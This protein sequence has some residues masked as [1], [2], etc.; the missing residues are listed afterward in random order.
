MKKTLAELYGEYE[1]SIKLQQEI[2]NLNRKKLNT[3]QKKFNFSEIQ[4][5]NKLLRT[6]YEEKYEMEEAIKE[7]RAYI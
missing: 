7:M 6:L 4:R 5:L 3:A 1:N 2:I